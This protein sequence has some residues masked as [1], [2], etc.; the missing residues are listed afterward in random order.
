MKNELINASREN[1]TINSGRVIRNG[2]DEKDQQSIKAKTLNQ[3]VDLS[4]A[5]LKFP[6]TE[7]VTPYRSVGYGI[8]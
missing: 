3:T 4:N 1:E 8:Y 5:S 6:E 7:T 2:I